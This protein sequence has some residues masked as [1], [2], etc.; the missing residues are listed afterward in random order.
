MLARGVR[1]QKDPRTGDELLLFP[2]GVLHLSDT[3]T[4]I[5]RLCDGHRA[6]EEITGI[7]ATEYEVEAQALAKDV[8]DCLRDLYDRKLVVV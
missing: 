4:E 7:L 3:A 2:E 8:L 6:I 5:L 1:L